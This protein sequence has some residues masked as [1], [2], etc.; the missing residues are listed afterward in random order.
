[1][2]VLKTPDD[3]EIAVVHINADGTTTQVY[4]NTLQIISEEIVEEEIIDYD[5]GGDEGDEMAEQIV[6]QE[7]E[8]HDE[9]DVI[10]ENY[11]ITKI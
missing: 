4:E 2:S 7:I 11:L 5:D 1:M 10:F 9:D 6:V 8:E 3:Y